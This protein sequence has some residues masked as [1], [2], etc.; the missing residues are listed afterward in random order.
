LGGA[1]YP[2][3]VGVVTPTDYFIQASFL[4]LAML[5]I[6]G[7]TSMAGAVVG[8]ALVSLITDSLLQLE[9]TQGL[10]SV[11]IS[12]PNGMDTLIVAV[13]LVLILIV[14]PSGLM[15]GREVGVP[16]RLRRWIT[17]PP[18]QAGAPPPEEHEPPIAIPAS[19]LPDA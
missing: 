13:I 14:R 4:M 1:K 8:T 18:P 15:G 5:V 6:G 3:F 17:G 16:P 12:L 19:D 7:V 9:S 2:H 11:T 10:L